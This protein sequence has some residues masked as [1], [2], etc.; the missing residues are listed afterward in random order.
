LADASAWKK[1]QNIHL[2]EKPYRCEICNKMFSLSRCQ[3]VRQYSQTDHKPY[4]CA[5]CQK[6]SLQSLSL[7]RYICTYSAEKPYNCEICKREFHE[8]Q[9][10]DKQITSSHS[11]KAYICEIFDKGF[12]NSR[13]FWN[14]PPL[15]TVWRICP[16]LFSENCLYLHLWI[17]WSCTPSL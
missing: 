6:D 12:S 15:G 10:L 1:H 11:N 4:N 2:G 9:S 5:M 8:S 7:S 17:M 13:S 14:T 3:L 16:L